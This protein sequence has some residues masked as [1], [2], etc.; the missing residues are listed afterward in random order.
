MRWPIRSQEDYLLQK[1]SEAV[2]GIDQEHLE[3]LK[4][5][6]VNLKVVLLTNACVY[7]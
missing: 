4:K 6:D 5:R 7:N 1:S 3:H 2:H